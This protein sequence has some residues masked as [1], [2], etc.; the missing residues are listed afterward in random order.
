MGTPVG[1]GG[2]ATVTVAST[3]PSKRKAATLGRVR[4]GW[5]AVL[6]TRPSSPCR[7][8]SSL[9]NWSHP[10]THPPTRTSTLLP[11]P[12]QHHRLDLHSWCAA[13]SAGSNSAASAASASAPAPAATARDIRSAVCPLS[14]IQDVPRVTMGGEDSNVYILNISGG[15]MGQDLIG[16]G[17]RLVWERTA[18]A[19]LKL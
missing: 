19:S 15:G 8:W 2:T 7:C 16:P 10:P 13:A 14:A 1:G 11:A 3:G 17:L 6:L 9:S 18:T 12:P 4:K 5:R